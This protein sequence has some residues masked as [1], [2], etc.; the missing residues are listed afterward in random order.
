MW[1]CNLNMWS[2]TPF[3]G[4]STNILI[5]FP[6]SQS[7]SFNRLLSHWMRHLLHLPHLRHP[8]DD[9]GQA[10]VRPQSRGVHLCCPQPLLGYNQPLP[11]HIGYL[12]EFKSILNLISIFL[13][14]YRYELSIY[15]IIRSSNFI[16][17]N[18]SIIQLTLL[19]QVTQ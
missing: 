10:Q 1:K 11:L 5:M 19:P 4:N 15:L 17:F 13:Y 12:W 3:C 6:L 2:S 8:D 18:D 14:T 16:I 7:D 9:G